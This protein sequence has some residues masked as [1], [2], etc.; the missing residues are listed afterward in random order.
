M[1]RLLKS[2][3]NLQPQ[4]I[5]QLL[6]DL[7]NWCVHQ[8]DKSPLQID[9][10]RAASDDPATWTT[11]DKAYHAWLTNKR[12]WGIGFCF[13]LDHSIYGTD[14]DEPNATTDELTAKLETYVETSAS[15][16]GYH[17]MSF[18]LLESG[19]TRALNLLKAKTK[20]P[21]QFRLDDR[22]KPLPGF[23]SAQATAANSIV[24][25]MKK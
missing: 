10:R 5:P 22:R 7:P 18:P 24:E 17:A 19:L 12:L 9:G 21:G 20:P 14:F 6:K 15:G 8:E 1:K 13:P 2:R 4:N 23:T 16:T 3:V 11:F 25:K